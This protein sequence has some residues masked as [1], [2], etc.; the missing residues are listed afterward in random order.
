MLQ[1][2]GQVVNTFTQDGG[3]DKDGKEFDARHKVQLLGEFDLPNGDIKHDLVDLKVENLDDWTGFKGQQ[4]TV[5]IGVYAPSKG[6]VIY[7]IK[8]GSKPKRTGELM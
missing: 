3:K 4:I 5:D 2:T 7:F 6:T 1:M 8:K